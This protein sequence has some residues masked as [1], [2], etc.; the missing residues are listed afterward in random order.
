MESKEP[1]VTVG[2]RNLNAEE[3]FLSPIENPQD[4]SLK[5][6]YERMQKQ[7]GKVITP[8]KVFS[9]RLPLSFFQWTGK[10]NELDNELRLPMETALLIRQQVAR[11]NVCL[12]CMDTSRWAAINHLKIDEAKIDALAEFKTSPLFTEPERAALDYATELTRDKK[13]NPATF[14]RLSEHY[15]EREICEIV[16]LVASEHVYNMTNIGLNIHSDMLCKIN[17]NRSRT[18]SESG[19]HESSAK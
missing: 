18:Y 11:I 13:I 7:F 8:V 2:S 5:Q 10:I 17:P 9:A 15:P 4:P 16:Y 12:F 6:T 19:S 1:L 3:P 14:K